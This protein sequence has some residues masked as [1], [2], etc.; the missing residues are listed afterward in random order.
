MKKK[1]FF[2]QTK[3][4]AKIVELHQEHSLPLNI[5]VG[6][7]VGSLTCITFEYEKIDYHLVAWLVKKGNQFYTHLPL[8]E[9]L[10]G[11]D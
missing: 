7:R 8:A 10:N 2:V 5:I 6:E 3:I 1:E 11:N 4:A 9:M